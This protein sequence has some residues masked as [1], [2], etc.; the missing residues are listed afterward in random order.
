MSSST[1]PYRLTADDNIPVVT[2]TLVTEADDKEQKHQPTLPIYNLSLP[3]NLHILYTNDGQKQMLSRVPIV[4]IECPKCRK[5]K[6]LTKIRTFPNCITWTCVGVTF[7]LFWP[8][9]W[10]PLVIDAVS[11][12]FILT[13]FYIH[14]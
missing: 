13:F 12:C 11:V 6:A 2:A 1:Q 7:F 10:L 9:C 5:Q 14:N 8:V 3:N 4:M